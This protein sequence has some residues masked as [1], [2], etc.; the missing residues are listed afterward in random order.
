MSAFTFLLNKASR[1]RG[2][3]LLLALLSFAYQARPVRDC[4]KQV[5]T[6]DNSLGRMCMNA[7]SDCSTK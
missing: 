4:L 7:C 1:S 6:A 5:V 2:L 3:T